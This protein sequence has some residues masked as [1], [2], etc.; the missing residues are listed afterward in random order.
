M[1]QAHKLNEAQ[2]CRVLH[3]CRSRRHPLR[4]TTIFLAS[5]YAGLRAKEITA[6]KLGD[7]FD[8]AGNM[9]EQ[10]ILGAEQRKCRQ[11]R[12]VYLNQH[13]RKAL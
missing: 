1:L 7:V 11:R 10:F 13:L 9:W 12:T 4:D 6:L 3:Y 5:F 2:F 8:E